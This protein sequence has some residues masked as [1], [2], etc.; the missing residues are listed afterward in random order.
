MNKHFLSASAA[1]IFLAPTSVALAET[2]TGS[3]AIVSALLRMTSL[4]SLWVLYLL[5]AL[6][7]LSVSV[8][9]ERAW[10]FARQRTDLVKLTAALQERLVAKDWDA[11]A[12]LCRSGSSFEAKV[13]MVAIES[14][15]LNTE[16]AEKSVEGY[17]AAH[18][19]YLDRGLT[20]LGTLGNN[21]PFIGLF[22]TVLGIIEAFHQLAANPAGG[23]AVVMSAISEALVATAVGLAVAIPAVIAFNTFQ[24]MV[25]TKLENAAALQGLVLGHAARRSGDQQHSNVA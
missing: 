24:R 10:F 12:D 9:V 23:A 20:F 11:A 17:I 15:S 4:G 14:R 6:S 8:I 5:I 13:A 22:G 25:K 21:A 1:A 18:K 7:I 16:A 2:A 19:R 3:P